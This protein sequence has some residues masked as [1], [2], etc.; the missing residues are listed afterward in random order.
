MDIVQ[1]EDLSDKNREFFQELMREVEIKNA[2]A[3]KV[4]NHG[5]VAVGNTEEEER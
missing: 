4:L 5:L 1:Q 3:K 2:I